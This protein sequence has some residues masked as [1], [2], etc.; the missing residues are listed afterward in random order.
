MTKTATDW[1]AYLEA[2]PRS[3]PDLS[4]A[5]VLREQAKEIEGLISDNARLMES[6]TGEVN[7][8]ERLRGLLTCSRCGAPATKWLRAQLAAVE[9]KATLAKTASGGT[10]RCGQHGLP[11]E[12]QG[13]RIGCRK[14]FEVNRKR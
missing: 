4:I 8:S 1:I 12:I 2:E 9:P 11:N 14:C 10:L 7:E 13:D 3:E 6:L 5:A